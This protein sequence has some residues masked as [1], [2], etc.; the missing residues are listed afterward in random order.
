MFQRASSSGIYTGTR[1]PLKPTTARSVGRTVRP[2][3]Q[4]LWSTGGFKILVQRGLRACR[5]DIGLPLLGASRNGRAAGVGLDVG[6]PR[7]SQL[8]SAPA[9]CSAKAR[10][11]TRIL[12]RRT[13]PFPPFLFPNRVPH[14]FIPKILL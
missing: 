11:S 6:L 2:H 7:P 14:G 8:P 9:V 13:A 3:C 4:L 12:G 10:F 1:A 5:S